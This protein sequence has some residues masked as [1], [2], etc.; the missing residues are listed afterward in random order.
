MSFKVSVIIPVYNAEK[1]LHRAVESAVHLPEVSEVILVEDN[2]PDNCLE[3]CQQLVV[4]Y[5]KVKLFQHPNGENR[6]AG[7]S[8][9][10]GIANAK[11]DF[12]AFLDADDYYLPNRFKMPPKIFES[13]P[14]T[15]GVYGCTEAVFKN[16]EVKKKFLAR[17]NS[18]TTTV[19]QNIPTD[20]LLFYLLFGGKGRFHTNA[21]TLRK[22][23]FEKVGYFDPELRMAQDSELWARIAALCTVRPGQIDFP[24]AHRNVHEANRIHAEDEVIDTYKTMMCRKLFYWAI[25]R[26]ELPFYKKNYFFMLYRQVDKEEGGDAKFL[27]RLAK[28]K[29]SILASKYFYRKV[30]QIVTKV[31][32][33]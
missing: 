6:G 30:F 33:A 28:T 32:R 29:P 21:I 14:D 10:L 22:T 12:I 7:A 25:W 19:T 15:D 13:F 8:R 31:I 2:S 5:K 18:P 3:I 17:Y 1:Y 16:D 11:A 4:K 9:N 20:E 27:S 23:V 26:K 24:V